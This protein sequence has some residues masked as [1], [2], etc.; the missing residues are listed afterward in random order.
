M[1]TVPF[2]S[3][4][5]MEM[6]FVEYGKVKE[7]VSIYSFIS[8]TSQHLIPFDV[9]MNKW[10]KIYHRFISPNT[11]A[12]SSQVLPH[13]SCI[14][15]ARTLR[16]NSS[17][18]PRNTWLCHSLLPGG[19]FTNFERLVAPGAIWAIVSNWCQDISLFSFARWE[20]R[21]MVLSS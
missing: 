15:S 17:P 7:D 8:N 18:C 4:Q 2:G 13:G 9:H 3:C 10:M 1:A 20:S 14:M 16:L 5:H 19:Y 6:M 12:W 11:K 21:S